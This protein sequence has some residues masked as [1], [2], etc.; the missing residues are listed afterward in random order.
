M[1]PGVLKL[2]EN[3]ANL[4]QT[5]IRFE[6]WTSVT[7]YLK[8]MSGFYLNNFILIAAIKELGLKWPNFLPVSVCFWHIYIIYIIMVKSLSLSLSFSP[9]VKFWILFWS[10]SKWMIKFRY[11][12]FRVTK[13]HFQWSSA[14]TVGIICCVI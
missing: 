4:S 1:V 13:T 7:N 2:F 6:A 9:C 12:N 8:T 11:F 5:K 14:Q 10:L 3:P